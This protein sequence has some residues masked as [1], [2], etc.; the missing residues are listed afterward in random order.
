MPW[1][2]T[3]TSV[4]LALL[5]G[6]GC[7][8]DPWVTVILTADDDALV[9]VEALQ[10]EVYGVDVRT[11]ATFP[12]GDEGGGGFP[13]RF[14]VFPLD[15]D[16]TRL[17]GLSATLRNANDA[18]VSTIRAEGRFGKGTIYRFHFDRRCTEVECPRN[19]SCS[20]GAC[21]GLCA[22]PSLGDGV[23]ARM[24]CASFREGPDA[25][26][27]DGDSA[28]VVV[29]GMP[30]PDAV[31]MD[32]AVDQAIDSM[33]LG[34][35]ECPPNALC[36]DFEG[37]VIDSRYLRGGTSSGPT[38]SRF[39]ARSGE[40]SIEARIEAG[41]NHFSV[42]SRPLGLVGPVVYAR[43]FVHLARNPPPYE[44][45][46]LYLGGDGRADE[47]TFR[48]GHATLSLT[49]VSLV[50]TTPNGSAPAANQVSDNDWNCIVVRVDM[51]G[52]TATAELS[53][54]NGPPTELRGIDRPDNGL[55]DYVSV[56][57]TRSNGPALEAAVF[58]DDLT[59]TTDGTALSCPVT[60]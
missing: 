38:Q 60:N 24:S 59:V 34:F 23:S 4:A 14:H 44:T 58:V 33:G 31:A 55:A 9:G 25:G 22:V 40:F 42:L 19:Q 35:D 1:I 51:T 56:G 37:A 50:S 48:G 41:N 3:C 52:A 18:A 5:L 21:D 54:N 10:V 47:F 20:G 11:P 57:I 29:D 15:G 46:I 16:S 12:V 26:T 7:T 2:P 8:S 43:V 30:A 28:D 17:W 36:D 39:V 45:S 13:R 32:Q 49:D 53:V 27:S 6:A